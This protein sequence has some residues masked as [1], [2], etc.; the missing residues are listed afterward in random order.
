MNRLL[1][2]YCYF[3]AVQLPFINKIKSPH[4]QKYVKNTSWI[5][6]DFFFRQGLTAIIGI[7][8]ARY[9]KPE[10]FG[11]LGYSTVYL[12]ILLPF[13]LLGLNQILIREVLNNE[14]KRH[15]IIGTIFYLKLIASVSVYVIIGAIILIFEKGDNALYIAVASLSV[16]LSPLQVIDLYFQAKLKANLTAIAQQ[17]AGVCSAILKLL[18]IYFKL[19]ISYF[20]WLFV[21]ETLITT[22]GF[23][24]FYKSIGEQV[25]LWKFSRVRAR[26]YSKEMLGVLLSSFFIAVYVRADQIMVKHMLDDVSLGLYT[27]AVKLCEP[28]YLVAT[29][30]VSSLFPAI[31]NGLKIS[32][33]EY[34]KRVNNMFSTLTW[35][36]MFACI[37]VT[38][39]AKP[40][41]LGIYGD[42]YHDSIPTFIIY[43]WASVFVFQGVVAGQIFV[44]EKLQYYVAT[45]TLFGALL[46]IILNYLLIPVMGINGSALATLLS[47]AFASVFFNGIFPKTRHIL[48]LQLKSFTSIKSLLILLKD[49]AAKKNRQ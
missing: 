45:Y 39:L 13:A 31:I 36:A 48:V 40:I 3:A 22:V 8:L 15:Q 23:I 20:V 29:L 11:V 19:P 16:L 27:A 25:K 26:L 35:V 4:I 6:F 2:Y 42:D 21:I 14:E 1:I 34:L 28:F 41:I 43:F 5:F 33:E 47:Y 32:R 24:Y 10:G 7:F 30:L 37:V 9:L 44:L 17:M 18:G 12:Q 38:I 46:N 49:F